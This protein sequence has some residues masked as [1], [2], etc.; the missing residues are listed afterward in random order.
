MIFKLR[1]GNNCWWCCDGSDL[2][3][4]TWVDLFMNIVLVKIVVTHNTLTKLLEY[5]GNLNNQ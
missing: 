1:V 4:M 3:D 2:L 5:Y